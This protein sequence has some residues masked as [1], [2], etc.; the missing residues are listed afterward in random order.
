MK[1]I[2][3][4]VG[5]GEPRFSAASGPELLDDDVVDAD[6]D[7]RSAGALLVVGVAFLGTGATTE[8]PPSVGVQVAENWSASGPDGSIDRSAS[9][10]PAT[11]VDPAAPSD[12]ASAFES[13]AATSTAESTLT[14]YRQSFERLPGR[15]GQVRVEGTYRR[16]EAL[17]RLE[18]TVPGTRSE[19]IVVTAPDDSMPGFSL[20]VGA[21]GLALTAV[22]VFRRRFR[23]SL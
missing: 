13:A 10:A 2:V 14:E 6:L 21:A 22:F 4:A 20:Q 8:G 15:P 23:S 11:D 1:P 7:P 3:P 17:T 19:P 18:V 5:V 9:P 12:S 16:P